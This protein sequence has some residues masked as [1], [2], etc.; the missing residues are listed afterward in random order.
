MD[1]LIIASKNDGK[2]REI[3]SILR[4][5]GI[6]ILT[7]DKFSEWPDLPEVDYSYARNSIMKAK[8]VCE[9]FNLPALADDSG[10]EVDFLGGR[11][12]PLSSR[13]S[14]INA[15]SLQN[16]E[17]LLEELRN[18]PDDKRTARFRAVACI[19][20]PGNKLCIASG[21]CEGRISHHMAGKG[22]FGYDPIFIPSGFNI[23]MAEL[24]L[25][26]KNEISHRAK[27][28]RLVSKVSRLRSI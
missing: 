4:P 8:T 19:A 13:Y 22:G 28:V 21:T 24:T 1:K 10:L 14:G 16:I 9:Y 26:Q 5:L 25:K 12:G 17:K 2:I 6:K 11:P 23:S 20:I 27:S 18:C 7:Y 15:S 3:I